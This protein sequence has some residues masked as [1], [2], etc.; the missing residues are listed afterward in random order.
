MYANVISDS[1]A[2]VQYVYNEALQSVD[3]RLERYQ[4]FYMNENRIRCPGWSNVL[5]APPY[6]VGNSVA[7]CRFFQPLVLSAR[8]S[9]TIVVEQVAQNQPILVDRVDDEPITVDGGTGVTVTATG[10]GL[11]SGR[12]YQF[13]G[14]IT[15]EENGPTTAQLDTAQFQNVGGEPVAITQMSLQV[16]PGTST[17]VA[18]TNAARSAALFDTRLY[19]VQINQNGNGTGNKWCRGPSLPNPIVRMP[20]SLFGTHVGNAIVHRFPGDGLTFEPGETMRVQGS[21]YAERPIEDGTIDTS[22]PQTVAVGFHGYLMV[23]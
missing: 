1:A 22:Y 5:T 14:F 3:V 6:S 17:D 13:G 21:R 16:G 2:Y 18:Q 4:E 10:V 9:L 8:D 15:F 23:R 12:P 20:A 19:R 11:R 7:S